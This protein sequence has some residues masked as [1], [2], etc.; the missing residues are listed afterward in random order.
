MLKSLTIMPMSIST[1]PVVMQSKP[2]LSAEDIEMSLNFSSGLMPRS[3][4]ESCFQK[5]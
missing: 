5:P 1:V 3:Y 4:A 2:N